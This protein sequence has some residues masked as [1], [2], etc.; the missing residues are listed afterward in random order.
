LFDHLL[1]E[2]VSGRMAVGSALPPE[3]EL[4]Q[5]FGLSR[6]TVREVLRSLQ[7]RGLVEI[8]PARGTFVHE[9]TA[10]DGARSMES[11]VRRSKATARDIVE[12]RLMLETQAAR[13]AAVKASGAELDALEQC[14]RECEAAAHPIERAQLDLTFHWLLSKASHNPVVE[15]MFGSIV[16]FIFEQLL[17][18]SGDPEIVREGLPYHRRVLDALRKHDSDAAEQEMRS[19]LRLAGVM[20][21]KDFDRT[22][23][24]LARREL[25]RVGQA[26]V[27]EQL[28][29]D[30][31]RRMAPAKA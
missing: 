24:S 19:H 28:I 22:L 11:L 16:G 17:R 31:N 13:L 12:A 5:S 25:D 23:D 3:R 26:L 7:E 14:I 21:G 30:V 6:P 15:T 2:I 10:V 29:E 1:E 27:L 4:A 9:A 18:S 8:V 20:Y